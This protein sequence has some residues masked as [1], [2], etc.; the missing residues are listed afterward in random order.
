MDWST[1][2][3]LVTL[4]ARGLRKVRGGRLVWHIRNAATRTPAMQLHTG[5][6]HPLRRLAFAMADQGWDRSKITAATLALQVCTECRRL[7]GGVFELPDNQLHCCI[8]LFLPG[9]SAGGDN[10]GDHDRVATWVRSEPLDDRPVEE[11]DSNTHLVVRNSVWSA[12]LGSS[13]GETVWRP[14]TCFAC[15]DLAKRGE[16]F[17]CDRENWQRYY[18]ST[19][20]F[21]IRYPTNEQGT[22]FDCIGFLAFDSPRTG[23]FPGLPDIY[24]HR[25]SPQEYRDLLEKSTVFH[26]GSIIVD[27]MGTI[28]RDPYT[29][30]DGEQ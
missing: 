10:Q 11:G 20:V 6:I 23:A 8:K 5:L 15:N 22:E 25:Q 4:G 2:E 14:F 24:D 1:T 17:R 19:L 18:R 27:V 7:V 12:L 3:Y 30:K 9:S 13:D 29:R 21:P 16:L 26:L 28:L